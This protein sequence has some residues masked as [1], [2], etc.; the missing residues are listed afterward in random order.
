MQPN[1]VTGGRSLSEVNATHLHKSDGEEASGHGPLCERQ[2]GFISAPGCTKNL[3]H[4]DKCIEKAKT[5]GHGS[6]AFFDL[7]KAFDTVDTQAP[8]MEPGKGRN[9]CGVEVPDR[10]PVPQQFNCNTCGQ[11]PQNRPDLNIAG[12]K[13]GGSTVA[14]II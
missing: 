8:S 2:R 5:S 6:V 9:L 10:G 1:W 4:L 14:N 11:G 7:A 13:I 3:T 12:S